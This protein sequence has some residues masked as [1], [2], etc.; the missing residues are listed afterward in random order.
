[1]SFTEEA[2]LPGG[3]MLAHLP[4]KGL[5]RVCHSGC[6]HVTYGCVTLD[7]HT[8]AFFDAL[9]AALHDHPRPALHPVRLR[10]GH[11]LLQF[12]PEEFL[13]LSDL[14]TVA[15]EELLRLDTVRRLCERSAAA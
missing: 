4:R 8:R 13:E 12:D 14:L 7:F 1:M 5:V 10:H 3:V 9:V 6:I 2:A 15:S 11:A